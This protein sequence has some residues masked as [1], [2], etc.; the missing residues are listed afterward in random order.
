MCLL[1]WT[2]VLTAVSKCWW[3]MD[4]SGILSAH[5]EFGLTF[6]E[7]SLLLVNLLWQVMKEKQGTRTNTA[8]HSL[9]VVYLFSVLHIAS[10][11][12]WTL[13]R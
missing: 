8:W 5:Y 6:E 13:T 3:R 2:S 1:P 11:A 10:S 4:A 9:I 12:L 7:T